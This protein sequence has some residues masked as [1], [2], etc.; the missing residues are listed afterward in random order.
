MVKVKLFPLAS[1][2]VGSQVKNSPCTATSDRIPFDFRFDVF[3][4]SLLDEE[5]GALTNLTHKLGDEI[6][7]V[8]R[9]IGIMHQKM[10]ANADVLTKLQNQTDA[11]V[12]G[13]A[14]S[15]DNIKGKV[16]PK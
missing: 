10:N 1:G 5:N 15:I 6:D 11:Y 14:N 12:N 4:Q 16:C 9:Q 3:E 8:W 2:T 13:S 7:Q